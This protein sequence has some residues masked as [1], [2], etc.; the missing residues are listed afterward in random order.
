M[1]REGI[2]PERLIPVGYGESEARYEADFPEYLRRL[3][4]NVR[5]FNTGE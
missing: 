4:R 1:V 5:V 3:D 2:D